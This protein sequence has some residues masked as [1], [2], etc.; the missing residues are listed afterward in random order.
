MSNV[1]VQAAIVVIVIV[2]VADQLARTNSTISN[3]LQDSMLLPLYSLLCVILQV[4]LYFSPIL[5]SFS[6]FLRLRLLS[7]LFLSLSVPLPKLKLELS[8]SELR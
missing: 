3:T 4:S 7:W 5:A 2:A 6:S 8:K 1:R